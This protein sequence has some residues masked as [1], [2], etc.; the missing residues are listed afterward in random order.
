MET[1]AAERR[2]THTTEPAK[3]F[4]LLERNVKSGSRGW[5]QFRRHHLAVASLVFIIIVGLAGAFAPVIV[6]IDPTKTSLIDSLKPPSRDHWL[7]TDEVGRDIFSRTVYAS[8]VSLTVGVVS[9]L[10][11]TAIAVVLGLTAGVSGGRI[12]SIIMRLTDIVMCIPDLVIVMALVAVLGPGILN[13]IIAIGI[14]GWP[15]TTRLLRA[16]VLSVR[17][18]EYV[19]SARSI[20]VSPWRIMVR[21]ILPNCMA[22][23][24]VA[25]TLSVAGAILT[26]TALS[27]LGFG[28]VPPTPSW[29][30]LLNSAR[31]LTRLESN[32]WL[33]IPPGMMILLCVL[34]INFIGDGLREAIDPHSD[35]RARNRK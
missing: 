26:E 14:L 13:V 5:R 34:A 25:G 17:E 7:G 3:T 24:L 30:S 27:F 16:Q 23:V 1:R 35:R 9:V 19:T 15:G 18:R 2:E 29:G 11:A 32:W 21:H 6:S 33:W 8:R 4:T 28:V 22:P 12:D 20:G 31:S 10:I